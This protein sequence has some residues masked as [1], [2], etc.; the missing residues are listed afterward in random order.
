MISKFKFF[1]LYFLTWVL[2]FELMRVVF[3]LYHM[4]KTSQLSVGTIL[5]AMWYGLRMD[6]SVAAYIVA[7]VCVFVLFG[8]IIDFFNRLLIYKIYTFVV[9]LLVFLLSFVDLEIYKQW[10]FRIDNTPLKFLSTPREA[11]ASISHLPL[12]LL[13]AV[14]L[15]GFGLFCFL[16]NKVLK[17]IFYTA[18]KRYRLITALFI[19]VFMGCL[20]IPIRG[21]FQLAPLNQSSVYFSTNNY[22]NHAAINASWNFLHS[23]VSKG[24]S[25]KNPYQY[26]AQQ[27]VKQVTDSLYSAQGATLQVIDTTHSQQVNFIFIVWESFTEKALGHT[28]DGKEVLPYFNLLLKN[29]IYFSNVYASGDR[30]NKGIPAIL[31]GYPAM[32]NTTIIHS[33]GKSQKLQVLSKFF[34]ERGYSTPFFYGGEPEFANIKSY[35]LYGGFDPITGKDDFEAKDMNSKWGAHDGVVMKRVIA[36]INKTKQPF[37]ATWLTLTSHEPFETPVPTVFDGNDNTSK[38]LNSLHYTDQV[39]YDFIQECTKQPW[40]DN[41]VIVITGDHGHPLPA[42][43]N[44]ADEFHIPMLW[45]GGALNRTGLVID[46]VVSQLDIATTLIRQLNVTTPDFPFSKNILDSTGRNWA[47]FTFNNG[48][49]FIDSVG[50]L[51]YDNVGKQPI[52]KEGSVGELEE[53]A[54]KAL[55]QWVYDDFSKK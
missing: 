10:G 27:K 41:T 3:M 53:T 30:T 17:R 4:D 19:I 20:I 5:S 15:L 46:K 54:G 55:M 21:G 2:F 38:F 31:S 11:F 49:G 24:S 39:V 52:S 34:R 50:R 26:L 28:I 23:L 16:F 42:S 18:T 47:F 35:L 9:L 8:L 43:G 37:F 33:P 51:V 40:W 1:I 12:F 25:G 13:A 45:L 29:G 32:P 7:P 22:A 14:F 6:L 44:K 36:D 48:F